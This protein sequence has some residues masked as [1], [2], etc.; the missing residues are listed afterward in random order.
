MRAMLLQYSNIILWTNKSS[1]LLRTVSSELLSLL[2]YFRGTRLREYYILYLIWTNLKLMAINEL[3]N[4]TST[5]SLLFLP[6][7]SSKSWYNSFTADFIFNLFFVWDNASFIVLKKSAWLFNPTPQKQHK[8]NIH[9]FLKI[10]L[11]KRTS[12]IFAQD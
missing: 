1:M 12:R 2:V 3:N 11:E 10:F 7:I 6:F 5:E 9:T 8:T 4:I